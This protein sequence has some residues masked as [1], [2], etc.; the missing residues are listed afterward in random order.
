MENEMLA[1]RKEKLSKMD[2][3][4]KD[5]TECRFF[6]HHYGLNCKLE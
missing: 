4:K 1:E 2:I 5:S 3:E 6:H